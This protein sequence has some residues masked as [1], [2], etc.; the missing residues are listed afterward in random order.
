MRPGG[1]VEVVEIN[2][3]PL[4]ARNQ[5]RA[6]SPYLKWFK[7]VTDAARAFGKPWLDDVNQ[8]RA[9]LDRPGY[10]VTHDIRQGLNMQEKCHEYPHEI[11]N[12]LA[13]RHWNLVTDPQLGHLEGL[14]MRLLT[15]QGYT[16]A[17]V[18]ALCREARRNLRLEPDDVQ[19]FQPYHL[20][21]VEP[22]VSPARGQGNNAN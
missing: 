19:F 5:P 7:E 1:F 3:T 6:D 13:C 11:K 12:M 21:C 2:W 18:R 14:S 16:A 4:S 20:M 22:F 9:V 10:S 15:Q 17:Q 8:L